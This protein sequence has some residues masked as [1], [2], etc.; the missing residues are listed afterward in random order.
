MRPVTL[1]DICAA[2]RVLLALPEARRPLAMKAL[3][4]RADAADRARRTTG[5]AGQSNGTLMSAALTLPQAAPETP[6]A[7]EYLACLALAIEEVL[8]HL[9]SGRAPH[10]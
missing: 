10:R 2:A 8:A 3:I 5:A 1:G 4:A 7:P 9:A 6:G